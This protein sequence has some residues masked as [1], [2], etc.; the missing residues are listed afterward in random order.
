MLS[1]KRIMEYA[2][3]RFA[4]I[5]QYHS[6]FTFFCKQSDL[7]QFRVEIK[8]LRMVTRMLDHCLDNKEAANAF[9]PLKSIFKQ[10]GDIRSIHIETSILR[11]YSVQNSKLFKKKEEEMESKS[12]EFI[13]NESAH[14]CQIEAVEKGIIRSIKN[15]E[16]HDVIAYLERLLEKT[17]K[18]LRH[19]EKKENIHKARSL[20]KLV[21]YTNTIVNKRIRELMDLD[22]TYINELQEVIG[23]WHDADLALEELSAHPSLSKKVIEM[24]E[25]ETERLS[26]HVTKLS[27]HFDERLHAMA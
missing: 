20:M 16:E 27:R 18:C 8:K 2:E 25:E 11:K 7:H 6:A 3:D 13:Q 24:L 4:K 17:S 19:N 15:L 5:R 12:S 9:L 23:H 21:I 26:R 14:L 1:K 10:A 22:I